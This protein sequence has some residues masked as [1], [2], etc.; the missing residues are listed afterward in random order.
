M[1]AKS[2]KEISKVDGQIFAEFFTRQK[3]EFNKLPDSKIRT[4]ITSD[5]ISTMEGYVASQ[6][7]SIDYGRKYSL[8][9][10]LGAISAELSIKK[11]SLEK[12]FRGLRL[13]EIEPIEAVKSAL[14]SGS[15][16]K[17]SHDAEHLASAFQYQF[18]KN[19]WIVFVT[20]DQKDIMDKTAELNEMFLLC[21]RPE[22]ATD[23]LRVLTR[24]K[25]P[26]QHIKEIKQP[27]PRQKK[28]IDAVTVLMRLQAQGQTP[29]GEQS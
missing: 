10:F 25:E 8:D 11:N 17:N 14:I 28:V 18:L 7:H 3:M 19:K 5:M 26:L 23:F 12:P 9:V 6:I 15:A 2:I 22:W 29:K 27:T 1:E 16:L 24:N 20:M 4:G 21:S 13:E